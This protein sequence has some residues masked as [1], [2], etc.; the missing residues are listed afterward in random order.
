MTKKYRPGHAL[1]IECWPLSDR[2][3][4]TA[5]STL[6][7]LTD[8]PRRQDEYRPSTRRTLEK[9][10]GQWIG[11]LREKGI[12]DLQSSPESRI[13]QAIILDYVADL[14]RRV[15]PQSVLSAIEAIDSM[16][17]AIAPDASRAILKGI[18]IHLRV[19]A[20]AGGP[21]DRKLVSAK[22]L[23]DLGLEL[24]AQGKAN[25]SPSRADTVLIRDGLIIAIL[26]AV[27]I[28][29]KNAY[30]I[31][32]GSNLA[33]V[34]GQIRLRFSADETKNHRAYEAGCTGEIAALMLDYLE[35]YRPLLTSQ[36]SL[37]WLDGEALW[38]N[39]KG[40][41]LTYDG[42]YYIVKVRTRTKFGFS[43]SPHHFRRCV[44]TS[45]AVE[46]PAHV[47]SSTAILGHGSVSM[48]EQHYNMAESLMASRRHTR[49][50]AGLRKRLNRAREKVGRR[51]T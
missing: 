36:T 26:A 42:F 43:V 47:W 8:A 46:D 24:I 44:A 29:R 22:N 50:L 27:P 25:A 6:G 38:L 15:R 37:K 31:R 30:S 13:T 19:Q 39:L 23:Y 34:G 35:R 48:T 18:T 4:W 20:G 51:K 40:Q 32:L 49:T 1:P 28:R 3:A 2:E 21:L 33:F 45:I 5:S 16:M 14:Q 11:W 9:L 7:C 17:A 41:P 10:Y 12:L